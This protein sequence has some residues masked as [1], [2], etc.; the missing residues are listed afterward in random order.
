MLKFISQKQYLFKPDKVF[1][2]H[3]KR[4]LGFNPRNYKLYQLACL[5]K[6][7]SFEV[8]K[9]QQMNNERLE[10]L[11]DAILDVLIGERLFHKFHD[12][13]VG[14]FAIFCIYYFIIN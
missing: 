5:H 11:G 3:L 12:K 8:L 7:S 9:D 4:I 10:F 14:F 6:S 1:S 2:K 13:D